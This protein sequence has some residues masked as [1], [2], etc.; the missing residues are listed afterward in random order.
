MRTKDTALEQTL[1]TGSEEVRGFFRDIR[2]Q[3]LQG[4]ADGLTPQRTRSSVL[5]EGSRE[6]V[7]FVFN[8]EPITV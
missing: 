8:K 1:L 2:V 5:E 7:N 3:S 4:A 6:G